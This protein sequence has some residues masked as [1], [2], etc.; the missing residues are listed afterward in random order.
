[1]P[2]TV[3]ITGANRGL[4]LS[5]TKE[6]LARGAMVLA[7]ARLPEK[8]AA[9]RELRARHAKTL[10][11]I[12]LDVADAGS[13][14]VAGRLAAGKI[15]RLDVLVNNAAYGGVKD[16]TLEE[17]DI[18]ATLG[19]FD[20]NV[21]GPLRVTQAML[22][23]LQKAG[24][25]KVAM[26]SSGLGAITPIQSC[27]SLAYGSSKAALNYL[28]RSLAFDLKRYGIMVTAINPGWMRTDMG[29]PKAPLSP[30]ESA[31]GIAKAIE[32]LTPADSSQWFNWDG[33][34]IET[35]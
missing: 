34:R 21:M 16:G 27:E 28:A 30:E 23:L 3:L 32:S 31:A 18:A 10:E 19:L 14:A 4:G 6:Y 1:M 12:P 5:L 24:G 22:P 29:G 17:L 2:Q 11:I 25:A 33:R 13:V 9:L 8:A 7:G 35:W 26:I 15:D 20:I